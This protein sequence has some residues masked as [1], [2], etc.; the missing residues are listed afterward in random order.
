VTTVSELAYDAQPVR[1]FDVFVLGPFMVWAGA[2]ARDL[3]TWARGGLIVSG[4]ATSIF[5]GVHYV[6]LQSLR[7]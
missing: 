3:P 1:V 6:A 7:K 4:I 5:N 2:K